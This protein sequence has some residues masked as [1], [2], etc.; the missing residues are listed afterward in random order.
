MNFLP[1]DVSLSELWAPCP[2]S[3]NLLVKGTSTLRKELDSNASKF[4]EEDVHYQKT[5]NSRGNVTEVFNIFHNST[6]QENH[7]KHFASL[8][9]NAPTNIYNIANLNPM[10][11]VEALSIRSNSSVFINN[12]QL[13]KPKQV[14]ELE[15]SLKS[16]SFNIEKYLRKMRRVRLITLFEM[17]SMLLRN[18]KYSNPVVYI[19]FSYFELI[20]IFIPLK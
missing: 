18:P 19:F 4:E 2:Q 17:K 15:G 8:N 14:V 20:Q 10:E 13:N 7:Q 11:K 16:G 6:T 3:G 1:G 5:F 9:M 12:L